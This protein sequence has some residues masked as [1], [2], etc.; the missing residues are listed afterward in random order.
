MNLKRLTVGSF[1]LVTVIL[2]SVFVVAAPFG[3]SLTEVSNSTSTADVA[4]S[5]P[6]HA[7]NVT[8]L[9]ISGYSVT[10]S[11]QGYYGNVTGTI[12]LADAS[13]NILYNWTLSTPEGEIYASTN[14]TGIDWAYIQCFNFTAD[15]TYAADTGNA[16][17][18][19]QFGANLSYLENLFGIA[20]DD[21]DGVNETFSINGV[22]E[23][24]YALT[25]DEFFTNNFQ[26]SA[27]E[28]PSAHLFDNDDNVTDS[29]FQEVLLYEP[30]SSS[31]IFTALL[32]E[33]DVKGFNNIDHD[34]EML[35]LEDGHGTN[36]AVTTYYFYVELE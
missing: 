31:V 6:A 36:L 14:G 26:F 18:T 13:D 34:F 25:H 28:C 11:W 15:G 17:A 27:G 23:H 30:T 2:A 20:S 5:Q 1:L 8:S 32:D 19:S 7:G 12:Q 4:A 33:E 21:V 9:D 3:G 29:T 35:V 22:H 24:G 16:G 10:Q